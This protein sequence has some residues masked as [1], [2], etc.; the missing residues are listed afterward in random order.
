V[1]LWKAEYEIHAQITTNG[2]DKAEEKLVMN[3]RLNL[4]KATYVS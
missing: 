4:D 3:K 2:V 1:S